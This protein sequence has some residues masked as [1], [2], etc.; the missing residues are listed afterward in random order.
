MLFEIWV[1]GTLIKIL[2]PRQ[3]TQCELS[4]RSWRAGNEHSMPFL[5]NIVK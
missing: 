3:K 4:Y 1:H 5:V 2:G